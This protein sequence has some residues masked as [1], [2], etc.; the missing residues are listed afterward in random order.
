MLQIAETLEPKQML[1]AL[2]ALKRGDFSFRLPLDLTGI[3]GEIAEA[4]NDV[5]ELNDQLTRELKR[6]SVVVGKEGK[7]AQRAKLANASGSW[8]ACIDSV[9]SLVGDVVQP[10]TEVARVIGGASRGD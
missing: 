2:R 8:E 5:V 7:I 9:N 1:K 10:I 3:D 4:F 6:M